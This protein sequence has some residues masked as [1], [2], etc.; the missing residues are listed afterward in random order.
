M[1]DAGLKT[2]E[3][4]AV[5][6]KPTAGVASKRQRRRTVFSRY[7]FR[8]YRDWR[9]ILFVMVIILGGTIY[10]GYDLFSK[11]RAGDAF[12]IQQTK[13]RSIADIDTKKLQEEV[14]YYRARARAYAQYKDIPPAIVDPSL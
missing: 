3:Q 14:D 1:D 13:V 12:T 8:P 2:E 6:R 4:G 9:I 7:H 5:D 10:F 11:V